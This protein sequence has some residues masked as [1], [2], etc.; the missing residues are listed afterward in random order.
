MT[1]S[2]PDDETG[3]DLVPAAPPP[4]PLTHDPAGA[5]ALPDEP[6]DPPLDA[7]GFDP[8][9]YDWVPVLRQPRRDGFTPQRQLDF[10]RTLADTGCVQ[11]SAQAAGMSPKSCYRLRNSP[12]GVQFATAWDAALPYAARHL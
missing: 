10:I 5:A 7:H 9:A 11:T 3:Q 8:A 6:D 1:D 12:E 2:Y 4:A